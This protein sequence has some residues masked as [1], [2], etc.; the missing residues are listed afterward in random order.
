MTPAPALS[1]ADIAELTAFRRALHRQPELSGAEVQTAQTVAAFLADT[2]PDQVLTG[3][4]GHGL[5]LVYGT[6]APAVLLRAE[7]DGLPIAELSDASHASAVPGKGHLCGHDGHMAILAG[8]ARLIARDPPPGRVIL[9]FQPAEE[10]GAGAAAV[11]ADPRYGAIRPDFAFALHNMPGI[12]MGQA[13]LAAGPANCASMG[14]KLAFAGKTAHAAMP[15]SGLSPAPALAALIPALTALSSGSV[16]DAGFRLVT[17]THAVLGEPAFGIA[18]GAAE[19]WVT[20]RTLT[21]AA[22]AG[23]LAQA[24]RLA[25]TEAARAGLSL[26]L[27]QHDAFAACTNDPEATAILARA[28]EAIQ[29]PHSPA[30]LPIRASEDFG[31]FGATTRSAMLFLGAGTDHPALHNPDYDFPDALIAP[32]A[33]L[34][35][36][37]L[38]QI[39][40]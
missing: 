37:A 34:F 13:A 25:Q 11:L 26:S 9:L 2:R 40:T 21:D 32:G 15:D 5:A 8:V 1:V 17:I 29:I 27:S 30:G 19:L 3:L 6:G 36:H 24:T 14:L 23:L 16:A 20:L 35:D 38:R 28:A 33:Q 12:P 10:T 7:L 22:M 4:G 39:L 18:P 31:R